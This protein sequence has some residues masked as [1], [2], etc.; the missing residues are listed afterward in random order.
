MVR[1]C[2]SVFTNILL[3]DS[4]IDTWFGIEGKRNIFFCDYI[5]ITDY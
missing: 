5:L 3:W 4:L 2:I 1:T